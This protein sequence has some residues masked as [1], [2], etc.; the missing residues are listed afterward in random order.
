[1]ALLGPLEVH[2]K[3]LGDLGTEGQSVIGTPLRQV[4]DLVLV[5][6]EGQQA[7]CVFKLI[8]VEH[9]LLVEKE[10]GTSIGDAMPLNSVPRATK[11][12]IF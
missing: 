2:N 12:S 6:H 7:R 4:L 11:F 8:R 10:S 3:F 5:A 1:M 9:T